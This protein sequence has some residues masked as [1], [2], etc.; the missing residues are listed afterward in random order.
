M[1]D[2]HFRRRLIRPLCLVV[3]LP[4]AHAPLASTTEDTDPDASREASAVH[5]AYRDP[6][7]W[8]GMNRGIYGFNDRLDRWVLRPIATGYTKIMPD[9][10]E[11]GVSNFFDNLE[12]PAIAL[13][14][15]LQG[16]PRAGVNDLGRFLVNSTL[17]IGGLFDVA[18]RFGMREHEEDFGQTLVYWG[19]AQGPYFELPLRGPSTVTYAIGMVGDAFTNP[20]RFIE[21]VALRNSLYGLSLV[22]L[23]KRLFSAE[24]LISGDEYLFIRDAYLQRREYLVTDGVFEEDPFEDFEEFEDF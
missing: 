11:N 1:A 7:P 9:P 18:S 4:L 6:D 3:L 14:Q 21:R 19:L 5:S 24:E 12:N 13:N 17:G 16:K 2:V 22:D 23:R 20:V 10:L 15:F 8:I